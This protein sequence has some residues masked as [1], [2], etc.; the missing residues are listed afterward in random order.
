MQDDKKSAAELKR[1]IQQKRTNREKF[2]VYYVIK[3]SNQ[4]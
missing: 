3:C 4:I 1:R 2:E